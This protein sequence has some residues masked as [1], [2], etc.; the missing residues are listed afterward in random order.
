MSATIAKVSARL[1]KSLKYRLSW[2]RPLYARLL[3]RGNSVVRV[4]TRNGD[5]NWHLDELTCEGYITGSYE[6][7]MQDAI[8]QHLSSGTVFYDV[9]AHAGF[10]A[11][12]CALKARESIAFE[13][14]PSNYESIQRQL[15]ANPGLNIRALT[16]A[17]SDHDGEALLHPNAS[18]S[19]AFIS[20]QG[21]IPIELRSIDSLVAEGLP[22]PTLLK[23]DVEGHE[24]DVLRGGLKT[25][26]EHRPVILID[27]N[28]HLTVPTAVEL[29]G[30][31]GYEVTGSFPIIC[32]PI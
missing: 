31:L 30:P 3:A 10:H 5:F 27:I 7:Y 2:L 13:P 1:P 9:G 11:L 28:D 14:L 19:Q 23:I 29:L 6:S 16:F 20:E 32:S 22:A 8:N 12:F 15:K 26:A 24:G 21:T 18:N 17:L 25:F 4:H